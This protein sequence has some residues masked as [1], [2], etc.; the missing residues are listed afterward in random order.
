MPR[1][2]EGA[3]RESAGA[4]LDR[5]R[6]YRRELTAS[7]QTECGSYKF[8]LRILGRKGPNELVDVVADAGQLP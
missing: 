4:N 2:L 8:Q 1:P 3:C 5:R 7:P 6:N